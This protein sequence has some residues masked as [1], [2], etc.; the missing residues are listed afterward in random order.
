MAGNVS[1]LLDSDCRLNEFCFSE[2]TFS[3]F[4]SSSMNETKTLIGCGCNSFYA[5]KGENCEQITASTIFTVIIGF[6]NTSFL[7]VCSVALVRV[8]KF[9]YAKDSGFKLH[10]GTVTAILTLIAALSL[11][12][13]HLTTGIASALATEG[14]FLS[15]RYLTSDPYRGR[16][17]SI[18]FAGAA[19]GYLFANFS[20]IVVSILW[21]EVSDVINNI[22]TRKRYRKFV[23]VYL[24]VYMVLMGLVVFL[25]RKLKRGVD[26]KGFAA[27]PCQLALIIA[28]SVGSQR[29][30]DLL[31]RASGPKISTVSSLSKEE[32][33]EIS[34][35]NDNTDADSK[36]NGTVSVRNQGPNPRR[37]YGRNINLQWRN[38][39]LRVRNTALAM[40]IAVSCQ[41]VSGLLFSILQVAHRQGDVNGFRQSVYPGHFWGISKILYVVNAATLTAIVVIVSNYLY[42]NTKQRM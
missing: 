15:P 40:I 20:A 19:C 18:G 21:V 30:T 9:H 3:K 10:A 13:W 32:Q 28:Y 5:W 41:L 22:E 35:S 17:N 7:V 1:C 25:E 37:I 38:I 11:T 14:Q 34:S 27:I 6:I 29:F 39:A 42:G 16:Y 4:G 24:L 8:L 26:L 36:T 23:L 2:S 31:H 33:F 12:L